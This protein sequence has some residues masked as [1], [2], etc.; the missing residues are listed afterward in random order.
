MR[1]AEGREGAASQKDAA[2]RSVL[3]LAAATALV[4][5]GACNTSITAST[6]GPGAAPYVYVVDDGNGTVAAYAADGTRTAP[7]IGGLGNPIGLAVDAA[8]N[9]HVTD[10]AD[11]TV[12]TFDSAGN[13]QA[14]TIAAGVNAPT[15][16]AVDAAGNIVVANTG[17]GAVWTYSPSG[18]RIPPTISSLNRPTG[19]AVR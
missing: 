1:S 17:N 10:D 3:R 12:R 19:V 5:A 9:L 8:G 18:V 13:R 15:G 11:N 2:M 7:F 16:I 4:A 14:P 6:P